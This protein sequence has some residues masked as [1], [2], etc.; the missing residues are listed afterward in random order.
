MRIP[1]EGPAVSAYV[2][3]SAPVGESL[4]FSR[5]VD[6]RC[7]PRTGRFARLLSVI[8]AE[9]TFSKPHYMTRETYDDE[10]IAALLLSVRRIAVVGASPKPSRHSHRVMRYLQTAGYEAL[11]VNPRAVDETILDEPVFTSLADVAAPIDLV[12]VFR[13]QDALPEVEEEILAVH[14][15]KQ[16][17][18]VWLQLELYDEGIATRLRDAGLTVV[19]D[20]CIKIEHGR[21]LTSRD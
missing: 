4:L 10:A 16:I 5:P 8:R 19:M 12:D 15:D 13:R 18:A 17:R 9:P 20:R 11:P 3:L 6:G 7:R 21:L 2:R 14:K 1:V